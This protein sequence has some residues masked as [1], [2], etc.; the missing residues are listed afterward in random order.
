MRKTFEKYFIALFLVLLG[1]VFSSFAN[2]SVKN[3][4][5]SK[6]SHYCESLPQTPSSAHILPSSPEVYI[7]LGT[8]VL[9]ETEIDEYEQNAEKPIFASDLQYFALS[10][11]IFNYY[12]NRWKS[13][14]QE[15]LLS[16]NNK[17]FLNADGKR[18]I[19]LEVFR[20]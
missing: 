12:L 1:S 7:G 3:D 2:A 10:A 5:T 6:L 14:Q 20:I 4:H 13:L 17:P 11:Y 15:I 8:L 18:F 16:H 19:T 9:E